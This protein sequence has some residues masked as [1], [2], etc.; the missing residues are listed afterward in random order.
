MHLEIAPRRSCN[1]SGYT[2]KISCRY[3]RLLI[4]DVTKTTKIDGMGPF[5]HSES[6]LWRLK[7]SKHRFRII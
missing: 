6:E 1:P 2:M 4:Y 7:L 5:K 3:H